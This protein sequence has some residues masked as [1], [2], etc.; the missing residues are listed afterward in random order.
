MSDKKAKKLKE[1]MKT[2]RLEIDSA[3]KLLVEVL[4]HRFKAVKK[5]GKLKNANKIPL[6]QKA[7]WNEVMADRVKRA[8]KL[9][10]NENFMR[11]VLKLIHQ[12]SIRIQR[13]KK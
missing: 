9:K 8:K 5:M 12:E 6:Y 1:K 7:R 10:V 3:D 2:L 4:Q 11:A 13:G